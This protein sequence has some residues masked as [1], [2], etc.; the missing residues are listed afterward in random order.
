DE[1]AAADWRMERDAPVVLEATHVL[2]LAPRACLT[3]ACATSDGRLLTLSDKRY[4]DV[5]DVPPPPP[6]EAP[7]PARATLAPAARLLTNTT[8]QEITHVASPNWRMAAIRHGGDTRILYVPTR[9][10]LAAWRTSK[11]AQRERAGGE[12]DPGAPQ[13]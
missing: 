2:A 1:A 4:I 13:L 8:S 11:E 6:E 9:E 3:H 5:W 7:R 10:E 12:S